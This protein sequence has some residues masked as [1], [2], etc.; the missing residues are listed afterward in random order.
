MV[1]RP[2]EV[3]RAGPPENIREPEASERPRISDG[4]IPEACRDI[5]L[6]E[7]KARQ[8]VLTIDPP[9]MPPPHA[10]LDPPIGACGSVERPMGIDDKPCGSEDTPRVWNAPRGRDTEI[11]AMT[12]TANR[13]STCPTSVC[14][15]RVMGRFPQRFTQRV[16]SFGGTASSAWSAAPVPSA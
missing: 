10:A 2:G 11:R 16:L 9:V 12:G 7:G 13:H 8:G 1:P 14:N 6:A 15:Q 4:S 5:R 3:S